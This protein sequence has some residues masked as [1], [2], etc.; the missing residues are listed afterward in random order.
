MRRAKIKL[1]NRDA[2][3]RFRSGV[4]QNDAGLKYNKPIHA[5]FR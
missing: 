1:R 3:R 5:D 4:P 2:A